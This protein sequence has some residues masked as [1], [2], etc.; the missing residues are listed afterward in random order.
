MLKPDEVPEL[1][2]G[3]EFTGLCDAHR[4]EPAVVELDHASDVGPPASRGS[5]CHGPG[6]T[7][8]VDPEVG[9]LLRRS[10]CDQDGR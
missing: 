2:Q 5:D 1:V 4:G 6:L 3:N 9:D 10:L 8:Y 7:G